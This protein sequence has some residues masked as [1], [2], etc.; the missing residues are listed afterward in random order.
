[1]FPTKYVSFWGV[2]WRGKTHHLR[3]APQI[4]LLPGPDSEV[5]IFVQEVGLDAKLITEAEARGNWMVAGQPTPPGNT[6]RPLQK[7]R[8]SIRFLFKGNQ[9]LWS[10]KKKGLISEGGVLLTRHSMKKNISEGWFQRFLFVF[11]P[12]TK[13]VDVSPLT[14]ASIFTPSL[15]ESSNISSWLASE[16]I[17]LG[18]IGEIS[19]KKDSV[20]TRTRCWN[21]KHLLFSPHYWKGKN[22][23]K[24]KNI[25]RFLSWWKTRWWQL[26]YFFKRPGIPTVNLSSLSTI[27]SWEGIA[28]LSID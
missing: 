6:M 5:G 10:P 24:Q 18:K 11:S 19:L 22:R 4:L 15:P 13:W 23:S 16:L 14:C 28:L 20:Q 26:K 17:E 12:P 8:A 21:F 3:N 1:M 25:C 27:A 2:K 9:W 7:I